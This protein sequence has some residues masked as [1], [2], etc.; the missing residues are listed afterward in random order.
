M[1]EP[2]ELRGLVALGEVQEPEEPLVL[3]ARGDKEPW[4]EPVV[5][6]AK[7]DSGPRVEALVSRMPVLP[8][9]GLR[10][11]LRNTIPEP[12]T[13]PET[14]ADALAGWPRHRLVLLVA[15]GSPWRLPDLPCFVER[16]DRAPSHPPAESDTSRS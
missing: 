11:T 13:I 7:E 10:K 9:R 3:V 2:E 5:K 12:R 4:P 16:T 14:R 8:T 15:H 6:Q 1:Q